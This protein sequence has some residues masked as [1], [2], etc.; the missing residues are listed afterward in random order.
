MVLTHSKRLSPFG[1]A[2]Q[3]G[4]NDEAMASNTPICHNSGESE[5]WQ[6]GNSRKRHAIN[7]PAVAWWIQAYFGKLLL[8]PVSNRVSQHEPCN[9]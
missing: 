3:N 9:N 2:L 4:E 1:P 6:K 7:E 8:Y 5:Q